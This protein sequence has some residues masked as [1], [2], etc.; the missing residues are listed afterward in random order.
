MMSTQ[1]RVSSGANIFSNIWLIWLVY[2]QI[3][4]RLCLSVGRDSFRMLVVVF[5]YA[6]KKQCRKLTSCC[7]AIITTLIACKTK[8]TGID[9]WSSTNV[10]GATEVSFYVSE[11]RQH[12]CRDC[13]RHDTIAGFAR[14]GGKPPGNESVDHKDININHCYRNKF[15]SDINV[16]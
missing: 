15:K 9:Q 1:K 16:F 8:R 5:D 4:F 7:S 6:F 12:I 14:F 13:A 3:V 10:F 11:A 2:A